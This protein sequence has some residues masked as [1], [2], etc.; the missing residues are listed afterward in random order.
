MPEGTSRQGGPEYDDP[1]LS[2]P[3][4]ADEAPPVPVD[5]RNMARAMT[6][7][8]EDAELVSRLRQE[9]RD[10]RQAQE[11]LPLCEEGR[12]ILDELLKARR[13]G[14]MVDLMDEPIPTAEEEAEQAGEVTPPE[15]E[16]DGEI[17]IGRSEPPSTPPPAPDELPGALQA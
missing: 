12:R 17:S 10:R 8:P 5:V 3:T 6:V 1:S 9:G 16:A 4:G 11:P 14:P 7:P 15:D 13:T 2:D